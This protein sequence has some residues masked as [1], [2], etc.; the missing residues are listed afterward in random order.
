M[1][2]SSDNTTSLYSP[3]SIQWFLVRP[4]RVVPVESEVGW[5]NANPNSSS[6]NSLSS[7]LH[8]TSSKTNKMAEEVELQPLLDLLQRSLVAPTRSAALLPSSSD[9]SFERTL[10]RSFARKL[11]S[12]STRI[13]SLAQSILSWT[14]ESPIELDED[15]IK[16]GEYSKIT[17]TVEGWLE[18]ADEQLDKHQNQGK[19]KPQSGGGAVGAK[20]Q[21]EMQEKSK[22]QGK[23]ERLPAKLL[24]DST[25]PKPQLL[26]T[27]RTVV[28][29]PEVEDRS[30]NDEGGIPL[31][32]PILRRKLNPLNPESDE[33]WLQTELYQPTSRFTSVTDTTPPA[34]TRYTHPY[35]S[36][37]AALLPPASLLSL[38]DQPKPIPKDSFEKTPFEWV[39][40]EK[41]L[42]KMIEEIRNVGKDEGM[43]ELAV[44]L[45]HHDF[46]SWEGF[47]CLIQVS[48]ILPCLQSG[49]G[50][51]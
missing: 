12:Q 37:L 30:A 40:D 18:Q 21:E 25:L 27:R 45:E 8:S 14:N 26:F 7:S 6:K 34:Y 4:P 5:L 23:L 24:H 1:S 16:D 9:L 22:N 46:R 39:G 28:Q 49:E 10:S 13:L 19:Y 11:D 51:S 31:W 15:L 42:E 50:S 41:A 3:I 44:D 43:K 33:S 48:S 17:Q 35:Q 32:K 20:T 36:E 47:T 38:P 2:M 29:A